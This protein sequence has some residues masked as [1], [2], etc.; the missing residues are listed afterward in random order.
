MT[1]SLEG[2]PL[3]RILVSRLRYLGDVVM[4]TVVLEALRLGDP[5]V[6]LGYLAEYPHGLV[7]DGHPAL[8]RLHLLG[9][10]RRGADARARTMVP[11]PAWVTTTSHCGIARL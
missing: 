1:W 10:N 9:V 7:L 3:R 2:K 6:Q 4:S 8:D 5:E 11:W